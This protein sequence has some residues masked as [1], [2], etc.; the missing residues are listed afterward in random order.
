VERGRSVETARRSEPADAC[1]YGYR[2]SHPRFFRATRPHGAFAPDGTPR[3]LTL[4]PADRPE[5][6][7][8]REPP[9]RTPRRGEAVIRDKGYAG[10]ESE[11]AIGARS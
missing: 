9:P 2:R 4:Q 5:R 8:A 3:A 6:E 10:R 11:R 7:V 1:G